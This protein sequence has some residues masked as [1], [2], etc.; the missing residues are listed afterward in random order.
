MFQLKYEIDESFSV[1]EVRDKLRNRKG[2]YLFYDKNDTLL[3][4]G[5]TQNLRLRILEHIGGNTNTKRYSHNFKKC[6]VI[7]EDDR[8]KR[9]VLE[10]YLINQLNPP[11][12]DSLNTRKI[13]R[14]KVPYIVK[15]QKCKGITKKG[16]KCNLVAHTNGYCYLHGG[17]GITLEK[18]RKTAA[19][20]AVDEYINQFWRGVEK[21]R[22]L[23]GNN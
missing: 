20:R 2:V 22:F 13:P 9:R 18:I 3:Y 15:N 10:F 17:N 8:L 14:Q 1:E 5:I 4:V 12:N 21:C 6:S 7:Y 11:L 23:R 16:K 19:E